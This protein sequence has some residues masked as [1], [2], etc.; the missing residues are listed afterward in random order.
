MGVDRSTVARWEGSPHDE[1]PEVAGS[2]LRLIYAAENEPMSVI[3]E[4]MAMLRAE[5][6]A[7]AGQRRVTLDFNKGWRRT[8]AAA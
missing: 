7:E 1:I 5:E 2:A 8:A 3:K 6:D 4:V